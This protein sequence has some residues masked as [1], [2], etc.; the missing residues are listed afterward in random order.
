MCNASGLVDWKDGKRR[1]LKYLRSKKSNWRVWTWATRIRGRGYGREWRFDEK[2]GGGR[3]EKEGEGQ[4]RKVIWWG[5]CADE[6]QTWTRWSQVAGYVI[7]LTSR[8]WSVVQPGGK[9]KL[10]WFE[11]AIWC[12]FYWFDLFP[13]LC[14]SYRGLHDLMHYKQLW[15]LLYYAVTFPT[16]TQ[17]L[18]SRKRKKKRKEES[19][20]RIQNWI[21]D[22]RLES[23]GKWD[24]KW[25]FYW[26]EDGICFDVDVGW[27]DFTHV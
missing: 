14:W 24:R 7:A 15:F 12:W 11:D 19:S 10:Y 17:H 22:F 26:L 5:N 13:V 25:K 18:I 21:T 8:D 2:G 6:W 1:H 3:G 9:C 20:P 4:R 23:V 27:I 16:H